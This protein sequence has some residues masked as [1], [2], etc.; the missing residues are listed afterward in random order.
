MSRTS[1]LDTQLARIA[2]GDREAFLALYRATAPGLYG[3]LRTM[4]EDEAEAAAALEEVY[5]RLWSRAATSQAR[6]MLRNRAGLVTLARDVAVERLRARRAAGAEGAA[7]IIAATEAD[8]DTAAARVRLAACLRRLSDD[9]SEALQ[10]AWMHGET[11]AELATRFGVP[12]DRM[13]GWL[14]AA[15]LQLDRCLSR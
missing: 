13:R 9:R 7:P 5:L 3:F 14:R 11:R 1:D 10:R 15:L 6:A 8:S 4:L 12:A 2:L